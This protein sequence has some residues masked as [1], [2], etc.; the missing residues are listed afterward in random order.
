MELS[1]IQMSNKIDNS[2]ITPSDS[3]IIKYKIDQLA[4]NFIFKKNFLT[5]GSTIK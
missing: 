5:F 2:L 4:F 1:G 3:N